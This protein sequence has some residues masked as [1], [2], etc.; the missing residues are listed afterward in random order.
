MSARRIVVV[1]GMH[2]SGTS[3]VA[4]A[5]QVLG[6]DL[7]E[8]LL[9]PAP[10]DNERGYWEDADIHELNRELLLALGHDWHTLQP[11]L[12]AELEGS[13][14]AP[15]RARAV[16]LL[17]GKVRPAA[18]FGLKDPR[19]SRL[20]PFWK[21]IFTELGLQASYAI[22]SRNPLSVAQSLLRRDAFDPVK[23]HYLWLEHTLTSLR[24]SGGARRI[25]VDYDLLMDDLSPQL[26]R[27]AKGLGLKFD[28]NGAEFEGFRREFVTETLRH[29]RFG[30]DDL[31]GDAGVP[32]GVR[33]LFE[34][35]HGMATDP[36]GD[37]DHGAKPLLDYLTEVSRDLRPA[38]A[39]MRTHE[40]RA[41]NVSATLVQ[42]ETHVAQLERERADREVAMAEHEATLAGLAAAA[43]EKDARAAAAEG[44]RDKLMREL[45][46]LESEVAA[47]EAEAAAM[48]AAAGAREAEIATL[49]GAALEREHEMVVLGATLAETEQQVQKLETELATLRAQWDELIATTWRV[50]RPGRIARALR[51]RF[52]PSG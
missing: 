15:F 31:R 41:N 26:A 17:D 27:L 24:E 20:L 28:A 7:G 32:Q 14:A 10:G 37:D 3:T 4:R 46:A 43:A 2:R 39:Y 34:V 49:R 48:R 51:A 38:L 8:N 6:V 23:T 13:I 5:L 1:L 21:G 44:A 19:I 40:E 47:R 12:P 35:L 29:T 16:A 9:P 45:E 42:R 22:V 36:A 30:L 33:K 11:V 18:P 50:P 52:K 25:V